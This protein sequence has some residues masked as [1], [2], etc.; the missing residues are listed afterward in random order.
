MDTIEIS[1]KVASTDEQIVFSSIAL[2]SETRE[3]Y[4]DVAC[5]DDAAKRHRV[6]QLLR[7]IGA[8]GAGAEQAKKNY[9]ETAGSCL[10]CKRPA[11]EL[12][13][14]YFENSAQAWDEL[15]DRVGWIISCNDCQVHVG[16]L[17]DRNDE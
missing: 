4:L 7:Q 10:R 1:A 11:G 5:G 9:G 12:H 17:A 13:W 8:G 14:V 3:G 2:R 15:E 6:E 16:F